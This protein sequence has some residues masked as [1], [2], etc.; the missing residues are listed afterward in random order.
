[1]VI[2]MQTSKAKRYGSGYSS[3]YKTK[4]WR[5]SQ[6]DFE[7][8]LGKY[9]Y[10]HPKSH[11]GVNK[12][13]S[14]MKYVLCTYYQKDFKDR[15]EFALRAFTKDDISMAGQVGRMVGEKIFEIIDIQSLG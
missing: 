14:R 7:K 11:N 8:S 13:L 15:K 1:M 4:E 6:A 12:A 2:T 3:I 9:A 10:T 5:D